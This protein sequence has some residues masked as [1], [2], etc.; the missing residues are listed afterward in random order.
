MP[1]WKKI[2]LQSVGIGAGI[3]ITLCAVIG[4]WI[5]YSDRPKPPKPWNIQA[6]TAEYD[7]AHPEGDKNNVAFHYILQN[8]T[9]ADYRVDSDAGIEITSK[10]K[11][12]KGLSQFANHY[13]TADYPI[14][15]P[16]HTRV[17]ISLNIPYPYPI[18][19]KEGPTLDEREQYK[20]EVA[21]YITDKWTNLDGFVLFDA[22]TRYEI[23]FPNGWEQ[24]AKQGALSK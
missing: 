2:L 22:S 5:W 15:V 11:R 8:N 1:L 16:A 21:R 14:F 3:A 4:S 12:E 17:W 7:Y 6:I 19:E 24:R 9:E 23:E 18:R 20:T 10:L 13:V